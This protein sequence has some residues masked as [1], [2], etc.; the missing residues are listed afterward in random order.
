MISCIDCIERSG[1][2]LGGMVHLNSAAQG[3]VG[4]KIALNPFVSFHYLSICLI[5]IIV[6]WN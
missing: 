2:I 3:V 4:W 5:I 1:A 6:F